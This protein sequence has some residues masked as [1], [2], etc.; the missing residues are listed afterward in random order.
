MCLSERCLRE[1]VSVR[2]L[3]P[4][5]AAPVTPFYSRREVQ[6]RYMCLLRGALWVEAACP[7]PTLVTVAV[8]S[9]EQSC[10]RCTRVTHR[11]RPISGDVGA[12]MVVGV[13]SSIGGELV[14]VRLTSAEC[15]GWV[16]AMARVR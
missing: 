2:P 3:V 1:C 5:G 6:G 10:P 14:T 7:S 8:W 12:P 11:S 15:R 16:D 9:V 13:P 4:P